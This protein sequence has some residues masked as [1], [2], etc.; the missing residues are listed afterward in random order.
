MIAEKYG[1]EFQVRNIGLCYVDRHKVVVVHSPKAQVPLEPWLFEQAADMV[2]KNHYGPARPG[3]SSSKD[4]P[5]T[6]N[7]VRAARRRGHVQ[8]DF[9]GSQRR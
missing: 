6:S 5:R 4:L 2:R 7:A 9:L 8:A 1:A 3:A